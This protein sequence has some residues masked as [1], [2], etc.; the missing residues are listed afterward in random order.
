MDLGLTQKHVAEQI[1][2]DEVTLRHWEKNHTSPRV[3]LI[4]GIIQFL[5]YAPYKP[6]RSFSEWLK[7]CRT[8]AGLS[9][10]ALA[11][12]LDVDESTVNGWESGRHKPTKESLGRIKAFFF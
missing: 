10:E 4:P 5:G 3:Y 11:N 1:G 2:V 12:T 7:T 8:T 6:T 9:Q